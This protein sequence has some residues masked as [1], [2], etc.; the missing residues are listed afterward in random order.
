[1]D[2]KQI[3]REALKLKPAE[4]LQLIECLALSLDAPEENID[5][6]WQ[7]EAEKRFQALK[8]GKVKTIPWDNIIRNFSS[9]RHS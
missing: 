7:Q 4:R 1:M 8:E 5:T 9:N 3:L 2:C 6:I